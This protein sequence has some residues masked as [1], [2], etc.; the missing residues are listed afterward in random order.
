M[1]D[2]S[3]CHDA[4]EGGEELPEVTEEEMAKIRESLWEYD[5]DHI[6]NMDE[7]GLFF[8]QLP[9]KIGVG[10]ATEVKNMRGYKRL[11]SKERVSVVC[12][13]CESV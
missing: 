4:G 6:F 10:P 9:R 3:L 1:S 11:S 8:A 5:A 12:A 2:E 7:S 13:T